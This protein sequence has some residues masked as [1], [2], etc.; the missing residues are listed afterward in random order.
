MDSAESRWIDFF[1][2]FVTVRLIASMSSMLAVHLPLWYSCQ[3]CRTRLPKFRFSA[4]F[5]IG[6][7]VALQIQIRKFEN[8][9]YVMWK[10]ILT[11]NPSW[12]NFK[13]VLF[14][15]HT[16]LYATVAYVADWIGL[17]LPP[18]IHAAKII[19][20]ICWGSLQYF[21]VFSCFFELFVFL[22][23]FVT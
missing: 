16:P 14:I 19:S 23:S 13:W 21:L 22:A 10:I 12:S 20:A 9:C 7:H 3:G 5:P 2:L 15:N 1:G 4:K 18:L 17:Y 11:K 6:L 8:D